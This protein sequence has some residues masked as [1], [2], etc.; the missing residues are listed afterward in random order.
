M[1]KLTLFEDSDITW[2]KSIQDLK[3]VQLLFHEQKGRFIIMTRKAIYTM[4][5]SDKQFIKRYDS[6]DLTSMA[7]TH[8]GNQLILGTEDGVFSLDSD[9]YKEISSLNKKLPDTNIS[10]ISEIN[11]NLWF[12]S[13]RGAFVQREDGKYDYYQSRRWLVDD[14][15]ID[16]SP[17][18]D[19]SV[20]IL[21]KTGLSK[22]V[23][24]EMTL[25]KK[26]EY[27]QEIQ[28]LRHIRHGFSY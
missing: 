7:L 2:Q 10:C 22:I 3:V 9:S 6:N 8:E 17:G 13:S 28:R 15:V 11:G 20:L 12:G 1:G 4:D 18:P 26:A 27:F 16:I 21:S 23:F 19:N 5:I 25:E 24:R 14:A